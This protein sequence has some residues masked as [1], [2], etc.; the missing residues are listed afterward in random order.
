[1]TSALMRGRTIV[2][3]KANL[4]DDTSKEKPADSDQQQLH[5]SFLPKVYMVAILILCR[6]LFVPTTNRREDGRS[7]KPAPTAYL[8]AQ[9]S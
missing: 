7:D 3:A 2:L 9:D 6:G 1:M 8:T 5:L 4:V